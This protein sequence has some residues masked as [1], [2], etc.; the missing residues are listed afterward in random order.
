M[1]TECHCYPCFKFFACKPLWRKRL[2]VPLRLSPWKSVLET[3]TI[4]DFFYWTMYC[5]YL[6]ANYDKNFVM[7]CKLH[8]LHFINFLLC[9]IFCIDNVPDFKH[10]LLMYVRYRINHDTNCA[11]KCKKY[12]IMYDVSIFAA[13]IIQ[14]VLIHSPSAFTSSY[15]KL[16]I[17]FYRYICLAGCPI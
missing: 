6:S 15:R 5:L 10:C 7:V 16:I 11:C 3:K 14:F 4:N 1:P 2:S 12:F 9:N 13:Y 8:W 17:C